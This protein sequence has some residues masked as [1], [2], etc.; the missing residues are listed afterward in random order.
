MSNELRTALKNELESVG[1]EDTIDNVLGELLD[2][3]VENDSIRDLAQQLQTFL[4]MQTYLPRGRFHLRR[5]P[6]PVDA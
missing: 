6:Q 3:A 1:I 4:D 5:E 2:L